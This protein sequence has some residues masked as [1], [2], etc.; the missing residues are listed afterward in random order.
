MRQI[1][2]PANTAEAAS[3]T[4][5]DALGRLSVAKDAQRKSDELN[6]LRLEWHRGQAERHQRTL[7]RL[8]QFHEAEADKLSKGGA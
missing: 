7:S 4:A 3:D 8:V 6:A 5:S 2:A 1:L